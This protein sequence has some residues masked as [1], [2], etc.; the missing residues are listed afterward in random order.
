MSTPAVVR[1]WEHHFAVYR[2]IWRTNVLSSFVQPLVFLAGMGLG[3]GALV[4]ERDASADALGGVGYLA[5]LAPGLLA[6]TA[7]LVGA[8]GAMWPVMD[9][10]MWNRTY[11]N[12]VSAP[13]DP[14]Q[15]VGGQ[16]L[17]WTTR[18]ALS[19]SAVAVVFAAVPDTRSSG[20][21]VAVPCAVLTGMTFALPIAAW[22]ATRVT[23][24][25]FP[26][27]QRF[28]I[29]PLFLFGGAFYPI[30]QLPDALAGLARLTPVWHGVELCR[31]ATLHTLGASEA[32]GHLGVLAWYASAGW[33]ACR[34]TFRRRLY[35]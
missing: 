11:E 35:A 16:A 14:R 26:S 6:T 20:L 28:V 9:G 8:N 25:S 13:L 27:L 4:D 22:A 3:V 24:A 19:T 1:V 15:V 10:F 12:Q 23:D 33:I 18:L 34:V 17:W 29:T 31:G 21:V 7:M 32:V 30:D 5:F 2:R